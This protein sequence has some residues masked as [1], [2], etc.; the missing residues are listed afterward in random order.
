MSIVDCY[1]ASDERVLVIVVSVCEWLVTPQTSPDAAAAAA[2]A[3]ASLISH[4]L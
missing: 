2:A 4:V 3:A 1:D